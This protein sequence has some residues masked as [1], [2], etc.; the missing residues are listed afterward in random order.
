MPNG[1]ALRVKLA[2]WQD[3]FAGNLTLENQAFVDNHGKWRLQDVSMTEPYHSFIGQVLKVINPIVN[4]FGTLSGVQLG[5]DQT[6]LYFIVEFDECHILLDQESYLLA[7]K[8][9][10]VVEQV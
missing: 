6:R 5:F 10:R 4:Q 3:P 8:G 1:E 9:F 7:K 2:A